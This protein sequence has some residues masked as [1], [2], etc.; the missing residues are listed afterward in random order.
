MRVLPVPWSEFN[1]SVCVYNNIPTTPTHTQT[2]THTTMREKKM[3]RS[4]IL[5]RA[6]PPVSPASLRVR[7]LASGVLPAPMLLSNWRSF[8]LVEDGGEGEEWLKRKGWGGR[9]M[10]VVWWAGLKDSGRGGG[11]AYNLLV[12]NLQR[13]SRE[14]LRRFVLG[15]VII[16]KIHCNLKLFLFTF[17]T[18]RNLYRL[19]H[20]PSSSVCPIL[21]SSSF[22][23]SRPFLKSMSMNMMLIW[24]IQ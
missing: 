7:L 19:I 14:C 15:V 22:R 4:K 18:R 9:G 6:A 2:H 23:F 3:K 13:R 24:F 1:W 11:G 8:V 10:V 16:K 17:L 20:P 5:R 12:D 21:Q